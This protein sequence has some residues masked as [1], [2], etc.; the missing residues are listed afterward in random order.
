MNLGY[1]YIDGTRTR[2]LIDNGSQINSIMLAYA[3]AQGLVVV[4]L[5]EL[6]GNPSGK[7]ILGIG[8]DT[9]RYDR[10]RNLPHTN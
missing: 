10:V 6:A 2:V 9:H 4:P 1:A 5:D 8:G 7:S 3:K